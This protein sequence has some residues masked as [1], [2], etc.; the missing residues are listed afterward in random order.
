MLTIQRCRDFLPPNEK[1]SDERVG[2]IRDNLY[3]LSEIMIDQYLQE[4]KGKG[5]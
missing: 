2:Q 5:I 4:C 3:V 1:L